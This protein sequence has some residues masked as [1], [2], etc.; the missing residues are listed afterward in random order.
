MRSFAICLLS[1]TTLAVCAV[2]T[3]ASVLSASSLVLVPKTAQQIIGVDYHSLM[4]TLNGQQIHDNFFP[5]ELVQFESAIKAFGVTPERDINKLVFVTYRDEKGTLKGLAIAEGFFDLDAYKKARKQGLAQLNNE[6]QGT[7]SVRF[8]LLN[9]TMA[10]FGD[11]DSLKLAR[12]LYASSAE[13]V[14]NNPDMLRLIDQA[15]DGLIWSILSPNGSEDLVI[16]IGTSI[17]STAAIL[18][19]AYRV[20]GIYYSLS[21]DNSLVFSMHVLTDDYSTA[22][23][24]SKAIQLGAVARKMLAEG[25]EQQFLKNTEIKS[26]GLIVLIRAEADAKEL[27]TLAS[28]SLF[29][30]VTNK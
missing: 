17:G 29:A 4:N 25:A 2:P 14:A 13:S 9:N 10:V 1:I 22:G 26:E 8:R 7:G 5:P 28:T 15:D 27:K 24:L 19:L 18:P 21:A 30:A 23:L 6:Q 3:S 11:A 20:H 12:A 16:S